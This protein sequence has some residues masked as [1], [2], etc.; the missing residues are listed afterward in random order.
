MKLI[1]NYLLET[2]KNFDTLKETAKYLEIPYSTFLDALKKENNI[3][4]PETLRKILQKSGD[5][6]NAKEVLEEISDLLK[7]RN[8]KTS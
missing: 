8:S 6:L 3:P 4:K 1:K 7:R 2:S 5:K